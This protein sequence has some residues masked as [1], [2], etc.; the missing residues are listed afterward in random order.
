MAMLTLS[1]PRGGQPLASLRAS[2]AALG[3]AG[4]ET[5]PARVW[6]ENWRLEQI[7]PPGQSL[8]WGLHVATN[9]LRLEL[10]LH[11]KKLPI[12]AT[13]LDGQDAE[14]T[15]PF[16]FYIQPRMKAKGNLRIANQQWVVDGL[17]SLEHAWGEL[18]MPGGPVARDRFTLYL[19]DERELFCIRSH[20]VDDTGRGTTRCALVD[21]TRRGAVQWS[22]EAVLDPVEYWSSEHTRAR[23]P[24]G[25][26]LRVPGQ[27]LELRLSSY[28]DNEEV[29]L[30]QPAWIGP[31]HL[32]G[33]SATD[34]VSGQGLMQLNG[35]NGS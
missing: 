15:P 3:L 28:S 29:T 20:R 26:K 34:R 33:S 4:A 5:G 31:V 13:D 16:Q 27:N 11:N 25:W 32:Y 17:V 23:Y 1:N 8:G 30:W 35:Y 19:D 10:R 21:G 7:E 6:V 12:H 24:I 14:R 18:P 22:G 9:E 2:R